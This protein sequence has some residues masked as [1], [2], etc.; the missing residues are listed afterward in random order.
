MNKKII[1]IGLLILISSSLSVTVASDDDISTEGNILTIHDVEFNL[2][3]SSEIYDKKVNDKKS[4]SQC[5]VFLDNE[6][7][8]ISV[9]YDQ[10]Y[11]TD[12]ELNT[13]SKKTINGVEGYLGDD[14]EFKTFQY[15]SD[16]KLVTIVADSEDI[17]G[18]FIKND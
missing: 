6:M 18:K 11:S 10:K 5:T 17:I 14:D 8:L 9:S 15:T 2:P 3:D 4:Q 1:L 16:G 12:L 13:A 7:I